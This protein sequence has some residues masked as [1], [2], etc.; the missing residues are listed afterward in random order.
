MRF[1]HIPRAMSDSRK[2]DAKT[3][4]KIAINRQEYGAASSDMV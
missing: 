3:V 4:L 1:F 2:T